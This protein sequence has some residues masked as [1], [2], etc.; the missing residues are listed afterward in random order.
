MKIGLFFASESPSDESHMPRK[1]K[2]KPVRVFH[3]SDGPLPLRLSPL[4]AGDLLIFSDASQ[5]HHSGIAVVI[6]DDHDSP[7]QVSTATVPT[8]GSNAL[9]LMAALFGLAQAQRHFPSRRLAL[10][11][12]NQ[13]AV[14]RLNRA[15]QEGFNQDQE[16][17]G[18]FVSLGIPTALADVSITWVQ[19]HASCRGNA[20]ADFHAREAAEGTA[21]EL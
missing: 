17:A 21:P 4:F 8:V 9:E 12:D 11:S 15:K 5:K 6:F 16:L 3:L 1:R 19:G 13:D 18:M 7:P 14:T 2:N 20:L 10:F